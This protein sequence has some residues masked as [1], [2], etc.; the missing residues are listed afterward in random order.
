ETT[1]CPPEPDG[2][3]PER[4]RL[5]K[6]YLTVVPPMRQRYVEQTLHR[7]VEISGKNKRF[8][9]VATHAAQG[10]PGELRLRFVK[11]YVN[12]LHSVCGIK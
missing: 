10:K 7:S 12:S 2:T 5:R 9:N 4:T 1:S 8:L 11:S 3:R 6:H